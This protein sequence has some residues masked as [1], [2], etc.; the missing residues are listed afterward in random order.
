MGMN[1]TAKNRKVVGRVSGFGVGWR[2][3]NQSLLKKLGG[4]GGMTTGMLL[5]SNQTSGAKS[6]KKKL[7]EWM[8]VK[9]EGDDGGWP[10]GQV[11]KCKMD[12][13]ME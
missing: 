2:G 7:N 10:S 6:E 12:G 5:P 4:G 3:T 9:L 13:R 8:K 11:R 1:K